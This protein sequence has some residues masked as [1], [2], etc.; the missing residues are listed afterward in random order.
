MG[1]TETAQLITELGWRIQSVISEKT[2]RADMEYA[3]ERGFPVHSWSGTDPEGKPLKVTWVT[4]SGGALVGAYAHQEHP[5]EWESPLTRPVPFYSG[6][7]AI[8]APEYLQ[9]REGNARGTEPHQW[10][11]YAHT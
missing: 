8:Y 1:D 3:E 5:G 7:G 10:R 2:F 4:T 9:R 11:F 6:E